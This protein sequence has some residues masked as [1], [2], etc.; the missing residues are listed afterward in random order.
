MVVHILGKDEVTG[1]IPVG[2]TISK[3]PMNKFIMWSFPLIVIC[4]FLTRGV[5]KPDMPH[6]TDWP[7]VQH[8]PPRHIDPDVPLIDWNS[9]IDYTVAR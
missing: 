9:M 2:S 1:S 5:S 3:Y 7:E 6:I 4:V 8:A